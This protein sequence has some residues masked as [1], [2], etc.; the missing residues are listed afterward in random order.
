M[1][2]KIY[3][4]LINKLIQMKYFKLVMLLGVCLCLGYNTI[5]KKIKI[6][7][8]G[9]EYYVHPGG[10]LNKFNFELNNNTLDTLYISTENIVFTIKKGKSTLTGKKVLPSIG[11]PFF[12]PRVR[13]QF[14]CEEKQ[15]YEKYLENLKFKFANKLYKKNFG[16]NTLYKNDK[17]FIIENIIRDCI[18]LMPNEAIDYDCHFHNE[19][20]DRTCKVEAKYLD[21]KRFTYFVD[22]NG[23]KVDIMN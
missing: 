22:D 20:F 2:T 15:Q 12:W 7:Y 11:T 9:F 10:S 17:D 3:L 13:K 6:T 19:K 5:D 14:K 4:A 21:N 18:I 16:S 23:K 1:I 8:L